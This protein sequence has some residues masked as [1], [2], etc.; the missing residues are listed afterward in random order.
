MVPRS[1]PANLIFIDLKIIQLE[2]GIS[3]PILENTT[4]LP[5]IKPGWIPRWERMGNPH[6]Y[7]YQHRQIKSEKDG[8]EKR[9]EDIKY[10]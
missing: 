7:S 3:E 1:R 10:Q 8:I 6:L 4:P 2:A 5:Y 9:E